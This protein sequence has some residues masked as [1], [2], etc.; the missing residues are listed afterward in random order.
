MRIE[1]PQAI[2]SCPKAQAAS[3]IVAQRCFAVISAGYVGQLLRQ[4]EC[5]LLVD[6]LRD[7]WFINLADVFIKFTVELGQ[8]MKLFA[9]LVFNSYVILFLILWCCMN[10]WMFFEFLAEEVAFR[11]I[12]HFAWIWELRRRLDL[13]LERLLAWNGGGRVGELAHLLYFL[14]C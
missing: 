9:F 2:M 5:N 6:Q 11:R 13:D 12:I 1:F 14:I 4:Q 3:E 7:H 10:N 8:L